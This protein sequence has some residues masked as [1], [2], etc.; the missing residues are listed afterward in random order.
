MIEFW[1]GAIVETDGAAVEGECVTNVGV[2]GYDGSEVEGA[3][4]AT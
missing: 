3:Y 1:L 2:V 4:V